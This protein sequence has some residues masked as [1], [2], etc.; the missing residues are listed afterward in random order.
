MKGGGGEVDNY[1]KEFLNHLD[2]DGYNITVAE[3][4]ITLMS[5]KKSVIYSAPK[6]AAKTPLQQQAKTNG[7][8][9][10]LQ[11]R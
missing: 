2:L 8:G 3:K 11:R 5:R 6:S 4:T 1:Y 10:V 7:G 9:N